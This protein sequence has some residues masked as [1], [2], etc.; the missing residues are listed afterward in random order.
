MPRDRYDLLMAAFRS[1][2]KTERERIIRD[3]KSRLLRL[4]GDLVSVTESLKL[5]ENEHL[6]LLLGESNKE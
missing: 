5:M 3:N 4:E 6:M 1:M 2:S